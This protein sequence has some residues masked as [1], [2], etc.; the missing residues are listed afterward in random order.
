MAM[1]HNPVQGLHVRAVGRGKSNSAVAGRRPGLS[2]V[3]V[4]GDS[5][6]W[7]ARPLL[8]RSP[9]KRGAAQ[10]GPNVGVQEEAGP[11]NE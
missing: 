2:R 8:P 1:K 10:L 9:R 7:P 3:V 11:G 6:Y 5:P 4:H